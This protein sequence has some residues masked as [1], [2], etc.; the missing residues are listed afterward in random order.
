MLD[1]TATED[2]VRSVLKTHIAVLDVVAGPCVHA[3]KE[4]AELHLRVAKD[5]AVET[6]DALGAAVFAADW[7]PLA[8]I[9]KRSGNVRSPQALAYTASLGRIWGAAQ[10]HMLVNASW[11][12]MA[13]Q[14]ETLL[15]DRR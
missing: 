12:G 13:A 10:S 2:A 6:A 14:T 15:T 5:M 11:V 8:R 4:V 9:A 3:A 7:I 1:A